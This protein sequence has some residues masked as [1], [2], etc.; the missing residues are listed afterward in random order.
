M[1]FGERDLS[2]LDPAID[3]G[4]RWD[5]LNGPPWWVA[6]ELLPVFVRRPSRFVTAIPRNEREHAVPA[7]TGR[8]IV[9]WSLRSA[10]DD[11]PQLTVG[12]LNIAG[13]RLWQPPTVATWRERHEGV[14]RGTLA[15]L[16]FGPDFAFFVRGID[17]PPIDK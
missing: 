16:E 7:C 5:R 8:W 4:A 2:R 6:A 1:R 14:A 15:K 11:Q 3:F 12:D 10:P 13:A 17:R 9:E